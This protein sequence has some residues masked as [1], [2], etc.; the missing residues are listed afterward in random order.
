MKWSFLL[1]LPFLGG[2]LAASVPTEPGALSALSNVPEDSSVLLAPEMEAPE[3]YTPGTSWSLLDGSELSNIVDDEFVKDEIDEE[4]LADSL[5]LSGLGEDP[6]EEEGETV[7]PEVSFD[8]PVVENDKV[9]YYIN[10]F[11]GNG[12]AVFARWLERSSRYQPMIH[13][14]LAEEGLPLDLL[15][16]AMIE[17][18]FN[19]NA[20]SWAH[21]VGPWQFIAST[22]RMYNLHGD[23]WLDERRDPVK[24]TRAAARHLKDLY[25]AFDDWHL[26]AAAY[27]AGSGKIRRAIQMYNTRDFWEISHHPYLAKETKNYVPKMMAAMIIGKQPEKYGFT[28]LNH[29]PP[30]TFEMVTVPTS[31]DLEI[32]AEL[33][34]VSY[35]E[36]K[37]LNPELKRWC[38][39]PG[40]K[41]YQVRVPEGTGNIFSQK[42]ALIPENKRIKYQHHR[43]QKGDTLGGLAQR[44]RI[45]IDDIMTINK[46]SNPRALRVGSDL[47]LPLAG[48]TV[49]GV[50]PIAELNNDPRPVGRQFYTVRRG[51][52]LWSIANRHRTTEK[53]LRFLNKLGGNT[54]IRPGQ[55]LAV[56]QKASVSRTQ[57]SAPKSSGGTARQTTYTVQSGD[58]LWTIGQKFN[59]SIAELHQWNALGQGDLLRP[60]QVLQVAAKRG[61]SVSGNAAAAQQIVYQ[62]RPGDTLWDIGRK[63]DVPTQQLMDWNNIGEQDVLRP[64]DRL[65]ILVLQQ[66]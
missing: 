32:V 18:G 53:E 23:W 63:F 38:T 26:A 41:N 28:D 5:L 46:I 33:C 45:R 8:F 7:I 14:V 15:Y 51:D 60:G 3:V 10:Y 2:C 27:N 30:M 12:R 31:T 49:G 25:Q 34:E 20:Y 61:A 65:T 17:S 40:K 19:N 43:V 56:S 29:Q 59:V 39:P 48:R 9:R 1:C 66:G 64:G 37:K 42:F 36:I 13:A 24:A 52:S 47:I 22:G 16:L 44:Y 4:T 50:V 57:V 62:V 54:T 58:S 35:E 6:P 55:V 11:T 21:A